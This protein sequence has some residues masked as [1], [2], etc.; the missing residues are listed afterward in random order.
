MTK[1]ILHTFI[2]IAL[3]QFISTGL[4]AATISS[5]GGAGNWSDTAHWT[6]AQVPSSTD[7]VIIT[8]GNPI[9]ISG[10]NANV[11]GLN[12]QS[13]AT[14]TYSN[15]TTYLLNIYGNLKVD[16]T[17]SNTVAYATTIVFYG[18]GAHISGASTITASNNCEFAI[19]S[20][21]FIDASTTING[22]IW[23]ALVGAVTVTNNGSVT[24]TCGH[25]C[26]Q[27]YSPGGGSWVQGTN[28]YF[29]LGEGATGT[30]TLDASA[31]GNMVE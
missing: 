8:S 30:G 29:L 11:K 4:Q 9:T 23:Y 6:P 12:I 26:L 7:S 24:A 14:L 5:R 10:Y 13:G 19:Y 20:S 25:L 2:L 27:F 3:V 16:G 31:S 22:K 18:S 21:I 17:L 1:R 15:T 28:S